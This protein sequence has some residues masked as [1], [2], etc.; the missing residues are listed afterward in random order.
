MYKDVNGNGKIQNFIRSTKTNSPTSDSGT[1]ALT[2]IGNSFFTSR[3][4]QSI[5]VI[6]FFCS[7][8]RTHIIQITNIAFYYNRFSILTDDSL[9]SMV[10]FRIQFLLEN[11]TWSTR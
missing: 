9:K 4:H 3:H 7:F 2:P 8:E 10:R 11:N 1:T 5:M 6:M